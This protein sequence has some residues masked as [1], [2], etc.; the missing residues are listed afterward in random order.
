MNTPRRTFF[1][2]SF[3]LASATS[4]TGISSFAAT[5]NDVLEAD[6]QAVALGYRADST[7]VDSKKYPNHATIQMCSG[8]A[9]FQGDRDAKSAMCAVFS[10]KKVSG[11]GWC[12]AWSKRA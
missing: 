10:N 4:L 5:S 3:V 9:L 12:S 7:K 2:K 6:Q 11:K 1:A 8:C